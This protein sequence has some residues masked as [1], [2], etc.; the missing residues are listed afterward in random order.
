ML[1]NVAAVDD[2]RS[3]RR[4]GGRAQIAALGSRLAARIKDSVLGFVAA[5]ISDLAR[6]QHRWKQLDTRTGRNGCDGAAGNVDV[7]ELVVAVSFAKAMVPRIL[8][9]HAIG[10]YA[11]AIAGPFG[12]AAEASVLR[13]AF[14]TGAVGM[15][16]ID[17]H[18]MEAFPSTFGGR[19]VAVAIAIRGESDP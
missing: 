3:I 17:V 18:Q 14:E 9:R 8:R 10:D 12:A 15:D 19:K 5:K 2:L 4:P 6:R 11:L 13:D 7:K 16:E 1:G